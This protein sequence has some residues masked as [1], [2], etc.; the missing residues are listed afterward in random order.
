MECLLLK[1]VPGKSLVPDRSPVKNSM[2]S[3]LQQQGLWRR[4][5]CLLLLPVFVLLKQVARR[6]V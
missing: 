4:W 2:V 6:L 3:H 5:L 1:A